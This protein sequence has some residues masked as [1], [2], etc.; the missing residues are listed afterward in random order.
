MRIFFLCSF[1]ALMVALYSFQSWA[2]CTL[3]PQAHYCPNDETGFGDTCYLGTAEFDEGTTLVMSDIEG[4]RG[5]NPH[6]AQLGGDLELRFDTDFVDVYFYNYGRKH[7]LC[8]RSDRIVYGTSLNE[9]DELFDTR[10]ERVDAEMAMR[11]FLGQAACRE[12]FTEVPPSGPCNDTPNLLG[13]TNISDSSP[14]VLF[15]LCLGLARRRDVEIFK[16][17]VSKAT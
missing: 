16:S 10:R 12:V 4:V 3:P 1:A 17:P 2:I 13:C 14:L 11:L 8:S 15:F 5:A 9:D 6:N 7:I